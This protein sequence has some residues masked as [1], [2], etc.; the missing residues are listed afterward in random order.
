MN[1]RNLL[2]II[3]KELT[4]LSDIVNDFSG[5]ESIH[6]FEVD[7]ALSKVKDIYGEL[8][9]LKDSSD[10][11][12]LKVE[13][14]LINSAAH[15]ANEKARENPRLKNEN[16]EATIESPVVALESVEPV[17]PDADEEQHE[18][19]TEANDLVAVEEETK[20]ELLP[21]E[22]AKPEEKEPIEETPEPIKLTD[23]P[24]EEDEPPFTVETF[25]P[26]PESLA[27]GILKAPKEEVKT[28]VPKESEQKV[29]VNGG[30]IADKYQGHAPSINDMLAGV[31]K[32]K[33]LASALK[34][35]P[36][37]DLKTAI[38]LNDRIW[39]INELFNKDAGKYAE[40]VEQINKQNN[41]DSALAYIFTH[42]NWDQSKKSTI[43]FLE[44]VFRRFAN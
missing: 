37:K 8:L 22:G 25:S 23:E 3:N 17:Q 41:L 36:I 16:P 40:T 6:P 32:N 29:K 9:L 30:T 10:A 12:A 33:D 34:D 26:K 21:E 1:K 5:E 2:K 31:K 39:Y 38:K 15:S 11:I 44:L 14:D 43:S 27:S 28:D 24:E 20:E 18:K 4:I 42:F 13:K 19:E 7:L 35:R